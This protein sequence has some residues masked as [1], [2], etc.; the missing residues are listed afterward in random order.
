MRLVKGADVYSA[1]GE[2]LGS[3]SR[4]II[5][6]NTRKVSHLVVEKGLLF[7][8]N[9]LIPMSRV[10]P[11]NE[12]MIVLNS[13]DEAEEYQDFEESHFVSLEPG[14]YPSG[15]IAT[16]YWY[17]PTDFAWWRTGLQT[18]Y[19]PMPAY[20]I[21]TTQNIPDGTVALEEGAK[22]LSADDK[23]VGNIEQLIVDPQDK[24]VTHFVVSEG[25]FFK[26]R[27]LIPVL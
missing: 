20:T 10:N 27:R 25:L 17:P 4:V 26:E 7:T 24:R 21:R 12:E 6:P 8:T 14:E 16:S 1:K 5:D 9:K 18:V 11:L 13:A 3:L 2:K 22:V 15:E 19:P 23:D